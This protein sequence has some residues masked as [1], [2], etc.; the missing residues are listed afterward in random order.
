MLDCQDYDHNSEELYGLDGGTIWPAE[1]PL[2]HRLRTMS[3]GAAPSEVRERCWAQIQARLAE[4]NGHAPSKVSEP[5][6]DVNC[7][8]Y[9]YSRRRLRLTIEPGREGR[10]VFGPAR[11]YRPGSLA[12]AF[13]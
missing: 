4:R 9:G 7:D 5:S 8:R 2:V 10:P 12:W 3:W 13:R 1:D 11:N 6:A